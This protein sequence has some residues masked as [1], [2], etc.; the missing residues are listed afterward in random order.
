MDDVQ[1]SLQKGS[2]VEQSFLF[3]I[4]SSM[5]DVSSYP[6]PSDYYIPFPQPFRNVFAVDIV[7]ATIP[8]TEYSIDVHNNTFVYAPGIVSSYDAAQL[9]GDLVSVT[10]RPGDYNTV[11]LVNAMNVLLADAASANNHVPLKFET[12][13][14]PADVTN[15]IKIIRSEPFTVFMGKTTMRAA[16]GFGNPAS[17]PGAT[18][19]WDSQVLYATDSRIANEIFQSVSIVDI[20]P[21]LTYAGP[22]P[23]ELN[24]YA[25]TAPVRHTFTATTSGLLDSVVIK[26]KTTS[27]QTVTATLSTE[28]GDVVETSTVSATTSSGQWTARF[29]SSNDILAGEIYVLTISGAVKVYKAEVFS[30][31]P[32]N[33]LERF[34]GGQ[35]TIDSTFEGVCCDISVAISGHKIEAPGQCNLTGE[36]YVLIKSPDVEQYMHRDLA[37]SFDHM[38]PGLGLVKLGG[39]GLREERFNFLAY[40]TRKFHPIGKFKGMRIRLET[41]TGRLYNTHGCNHTLLVCVKMYAPGPMTTIPRDLFPGYTPDPQR[42]LVN[43]LE[44]ERC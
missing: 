44:R 27:T 1:F 16:I 22:V 9:A 4:D 19:G 10:L 26:G 41:S 12:V 24:E 25:L 34:A 37:A 32:A 18:L 36:R 33:K 31:D 30:D 2:A 21:T 7:D 8:R 14:D 43:K 6:T 40:A 11:Q 13:T 38:A 5:R 39:L 20:A 23:V 17:T 15:T 28:S 42:A 29:T 35:W 3:V